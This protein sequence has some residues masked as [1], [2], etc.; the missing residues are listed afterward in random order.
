MNH[1][2][3]KIRNHHVAN[4]A[5]KFVKKNFIDFEKIIKRLQLIIFKCRK[6]MNRSIRATAVYIL[7]N[8]KRV[9]NKIYSDLSASIRKNLRAVDLMIRDIKLIKKFQINVS[10]DDDFIKNFSVI[11]NR[12]DIIEINIS[13]SLTKAVVFKFSILKI[14]FVTSCKTLQ[15]EKIEQLNKSNV[16]SSAANSISF[17]IQFSN[18]DKKILVSFINQDIRFI[19]YEFSAVINENILNEIL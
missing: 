8:F 9:Y 4:E 3:L 12:I 19:K 6:K 5:V 16:V 14:V 2:L 11:V 7:N 1:L 18:L 10:F 17:Q 15:V 13:T